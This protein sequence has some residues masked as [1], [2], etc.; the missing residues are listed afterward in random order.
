MREQMAY[1]ENEWLP[2]RRTML[3]NENSRRKAAEQSLNS[4]TAFH[5]LLEKEIRG[6]L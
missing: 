6:E 4:A 2:E 5:S 1:V 3:V